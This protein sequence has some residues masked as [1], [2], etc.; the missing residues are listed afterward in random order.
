MT[1]D[2]SRDA[3]GLAELFHKNSACGRER[4]QVGDAVTVARKR[5]LLQAGAEECGEKERRRRGQPASTQPVEA[6]KVGVQYCPVIAV[7]IKPP[8]QPRE[9][10][11]KESAGIQEGENRSRG[12]EQKEFQHLFV[13][14]GGRSAGNGGG[15]FAERLP[16]RRFDD[17]VMGCRKTNGA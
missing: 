1:P 11:G 17:E 5:L 6:F 10:G 14:P 3:H 13:E 15:E 7:S 9:K 12:S 8:A 4:L 2:P 16:G